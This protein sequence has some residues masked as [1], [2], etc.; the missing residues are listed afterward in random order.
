MHNELR[1]VLHAQR[2]LDS[3]LWYISRKLRMIEMAQARLTT[4]VATIVADIKSVTA[5]AAQ[6]I[7][8][9]NDQIAIIK[10][11]GDPD[12]AEIDAASVQLETAHTAMQAAEASLTAVPSETLTILPNPA[13][14]NVGGT[15]QFSIKEGIAVT[16]AVQAPAAGSSGGSIEANGVY[17]AGPVI[18]VDVV[19]ATSSDGS[20]A[21][22][23]ANVTVA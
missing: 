1:D 9:L 8:R 10:S 15:V 22:G 19:I 12:Q 20:N 4:D 13:S 3:V 17:T 11:G 21:S 5:A 2:D 16:W 6:A 23:S 14:T 7:Q 18:G